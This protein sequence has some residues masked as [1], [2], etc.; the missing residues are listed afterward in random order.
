LRPLLFL[1]FIN[2]LHK[3]DNDKSVSILF[4]EDTSILLSNSNPYDFNNNTNTV[5]KV[6][7][8]W[9]KQNSLSLKFTK[10]HFT[11]FT[12]KNSNQIE[13]NDNNKLIPTITYT[14]CLGLTVYSSLTRT[15]H[16]NSLTNKLSTAF[17]LIRNIKQYLY[18][19]HHL[20]FPFSFHYVLWHNVLGKLIT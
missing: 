11:K 19:E 14:K 20:S 5:F 7:C 10:T 2:D 6:T 12:S 15:N 17:Y 8:D 16:I 9:F 1:I 4:T 3:F 18:S 13:I